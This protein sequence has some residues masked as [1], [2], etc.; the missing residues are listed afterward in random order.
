MDNIKSEEE[1]LIPNGQGRE[2][3]HN[4]VANGEQPQNRSSVGSELAFYNVS[5]N[6]NVKVDGEKTQK[7][8]LNNVR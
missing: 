1:P 5:Y 2:E 8:L 3:H 4:I 6:I 7:C